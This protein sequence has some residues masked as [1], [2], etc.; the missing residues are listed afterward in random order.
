MLRSSAST[1]ISRV[2]H[3]LASSHAS[4][5]RRD[6]PSMLRP[7]YNMKEFPNPVIPSHLRFTAD[8]HAIGRAKNLIEFI[9]DIED[10]GKAAENASKIYNADV[11]MNDKYATSEEYACG[12]CRN[13]SITYP[14][15]VDES[16]VMAGLDQMLPSDKLLAYIQHMAAVKLK[17]RMDRSY[18]T[19]LDEKPA[20]LEKFDESALIAVGIIVEE[21]VRDFMIRWRNNQQPI[22]LTAKNIDVATKLQLQGCDD[23]SEITIEMLKSRLSLL[24][25]SYESSNHDRLQPYEDTISNVLVNKQ[26]EQLYRSESPDV[27]DQSSPTRVRDKWSH[28]RSKHRSHGHSKRKRLRP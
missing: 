26:L 21:L 24:F 2:A 9:D 19:V 8:A 25:D 7:S 3:L 10:F 22:R 1:C 6:Q 5:R 11:L 27:S 23:A 12:Q 28:G 15:Y 18:S 16:H 20:L 17:H 13:E 14:E 4:A